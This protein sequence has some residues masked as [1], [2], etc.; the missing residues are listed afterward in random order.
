MEE[1]MKKTDATNLLDCYQETL[2]EL[3]VANS[4]IKLVRSSCLEREF[5]GEYYGISRDKTVHISE[6]RN[7]YINM[8]NILSEKISNVM[9]LCL[10]LENESMLQ[11]DTYNC[12]RQIATQSP[13]NQSP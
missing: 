4:I 6:E 2:D 3:C 8:L 1:A 5:T 7:N 11:Q 10:S 12:C 13:T 9:N